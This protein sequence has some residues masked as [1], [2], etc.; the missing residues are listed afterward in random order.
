MNDQIEE[1]LMRG[2][3]LRANIETKAEIIVQT[4]SIPILLRKKEI[5]LI[6]MDQIVRGIQVGNLIEGNV[7]VVVEPI[8][9]QT[10][11]ILFTVNIEV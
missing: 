10:H 7:V 3:A 2:V 4:T 9:T 5:V 6:N 8:M 1:G 11:Q